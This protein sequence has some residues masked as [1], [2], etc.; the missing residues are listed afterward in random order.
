[1]RGPQTAMRV[2]TAYADITPS[3]AIH[4]A[5]Q[6]HE[7][8]GEY[9]HDPLTVNAVAFES[10]ESRVVLVSC[11]LLFLPDDFVREIQTRCEAEFGIPGDSVLIACT[12]THV[13]PCTMAGL[14]GRVDA[15]WMRDL[16]AK[17]IAVVGRAVGDLEDASVCAGSVNLD[18]LGFNRRGLHADGSVD[19]Y[20]GCWNLDFAGL[21]GPRDGE[22]GVI[23]ARR[24]DGSVKAV[25]PSFATHPTT[26][27]G[28]CFYSADLVGSLRSFLRDALGGDLGVVYLTGAAGNTAPLDIEHDAERSRPWYGEVGWKRAG[29]YLGRGVLEV[30]DSAPP[31]TDPVLRLA[32]AVVKIPIRQY[33]DDFDPEKLSWGREYFGAARDEWPRMLREESPVSVRLSVL[34]IGDAAIC[35]NPAEL[36]VEHGLAIKASS[37]ARVTLISELTDGYVGYVPTKDAFRRGGYSTWPADTSKLAEDA[38]EIIVEATGGLLKQA[39]AAGE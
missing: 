5:G 33:P 9:A 7:R 12:H 20:H 2:G 16:R 29:E 34:R 3:R 18:Q 6:L 10:G 24:M 13:A 39:F 8:V 17:L 1:M 38:G 4:V 30:V 31:M 32:Q 21:E 25:I 11:D 27:E 35:A 36:Y 22:L 28:D 19:M 15:E 23:F 14:P 37:P 26:F